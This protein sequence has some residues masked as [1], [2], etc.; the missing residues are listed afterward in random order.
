MNKQELIDA[1][2]TKTDSSKSAAAA[3]LDA[4]LETIGHAI[5]AGDKV[6]LVGFGTFATGKRAARSGRNPATGETIDIPAATTAKFTAGKAL[7][8]LVNAPTKKKK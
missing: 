5:A 3:M 2:A 7:K 1:I 4:T 6:A 8:E